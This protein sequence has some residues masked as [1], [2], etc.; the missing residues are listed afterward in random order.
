M[1]E[2]STDIQEIKE[3]FV[4]I[5]L[6]NCKMLSLLINDVLDYSQLEQSKQPLKIRKKQFSLLEVMKEVEELVLMQCE[7]KD[8]YLKYNFYEEQSNSSEI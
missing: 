8:L 7:A 1:I 5:C 4:K 2:H 6:K 3:K